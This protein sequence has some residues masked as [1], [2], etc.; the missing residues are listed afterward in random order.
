MLFFSTQW[1]TMQWPSR[2]TSRSD[3]GPAPCRGS[4][5]ALVELKQRVKHLLSAISS[6]VGCLK[7]FDRKAELDKVVLLEGSNGS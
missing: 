2:C 7:G 6:S 5:S 4:G 1:R 3:G